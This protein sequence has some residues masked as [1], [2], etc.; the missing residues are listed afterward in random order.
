MMNLYSYSAEACYSSVYVLKEVNLG[1][2]QAFGESVL[3][4][5]CKLVQALGFMC[6]ISKLII[7]GDIN[8]I[9][10]GP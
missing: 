8:R 6:T 4:N 7:Y 5:H 10:F 1:F 9:F 2:R 3:L